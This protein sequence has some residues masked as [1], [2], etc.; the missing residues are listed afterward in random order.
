MRDDMMSKIAQE[1][2]EAYRRE[3]YRREAFS[4]HLA[5]QGVAQPAHR[6]SCADDDPPRGGF[7][8]LWDAISARLAH[9]AGMPAASRFDQPAC[10][11]GPGAVF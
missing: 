2:R 7:R 5:Q 11:C 6:R 9:L 8:S 10:D 1:R 3:A 4:A